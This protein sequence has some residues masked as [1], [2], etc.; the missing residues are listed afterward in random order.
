MIVAAIGGC[1]SSTTEP[2]VSE[3]QWRELEAAE[4]RWKARPFTNYRYEIRT[5]CYCPP[6]LNQWVRV[7]VEDDVVVDAELVEPNPTLEI[8]STTYWQPID[9]I[10][11]LLRR[12]LNEPSLAVVFQRF[13][14]EYDQQLGYPTRIVFREREG[15]TD[16]GSLSELRSLTI[17][18]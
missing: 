7:T 3:A 14:A 5:L 10:F 6:V 9:S 11:T 8:Q 1:R 17:L 4:A 13:E 15:I 16:A 18:P 12:R 2:V